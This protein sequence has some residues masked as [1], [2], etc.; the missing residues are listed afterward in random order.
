M[1]TV[2]SQLGEVV[3]GNQVP[4]MTTPIEYNIEVVFDGILLILSLI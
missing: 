2:F 1:D 4:V 3:G